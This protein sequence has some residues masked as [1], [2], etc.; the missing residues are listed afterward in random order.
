ML[1]AGQHIR[2]VAAE[3][4]VAA[5]LDQNIPGATKNMTAIMVEIWERCNKYTNML[6]TGPS[7][8][9]LLPSP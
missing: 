6:G 5:V 4:T 3:E 8:S 9:H 7:L 1:T 2:A